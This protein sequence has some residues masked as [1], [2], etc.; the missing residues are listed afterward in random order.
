MMLTEE[1]RRHIFH[2]ITSTSAVKVTDLSKTFDIS[3]STVRRDLQEM[4]GQGLVRRVYG[5]A[6]LA[7][8]RTELPVLQRAGDAAFFKRQIGAAA[9][10]LVNDGDT[11]IVTS[12]TTTRAMVPFLAPKVGLTIITNAVNALHDLS[13]LLNADVIVL[14]GWLRKS[15]LSLIGHLTVDALKNLRADKIFHGTYGIHPSFGIT[16]TYLP[17]VHTDQQLLSAANDVIVLADHSKFGKAG[18]IKIMALT[19]VNT[20]VTDHLTALDD[21]EMLREQ[22][23]NVIIAQ[24]AS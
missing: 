5:G 16:G 20:I 6:V 4:E 1:R 13:Q 3:E 23:I 14:G 8:P 15:E 22:G 7:E 11:I 12:G 21:V 10:R 19:Q 9:A 24:S 17:E 18:P 2:L